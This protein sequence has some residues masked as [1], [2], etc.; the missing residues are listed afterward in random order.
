MRFLA[1]VIFGLMCRR[2]GMR[3]RIRVTLSL[4]TVTVAGTILEPFAL[5]PSRE[6]AFKLLK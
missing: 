1:Q 2:E 4:S 3:K 6:F 5:F